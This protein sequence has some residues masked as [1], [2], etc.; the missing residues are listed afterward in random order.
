MMEEP[1]GSGRGRSSMIFVLGTAAFIVAAGLVAAGAYSYSQITPA[2]TSQT[3][4][5]GLAAKERQTSTLTI[6][7]SSGM[8]NEALPLALKVTAP[9][10]GSAVYLKGVPR[11]ALLTTGT[12]VAVGEWRVA[13]KDLSLVALIP[14]RDYTGSMDLTAGDHVVSSGNMHLTWTPPA[15]KPIDVAK[16][17]IDSAKPPPDVVKPPVDIAKAP[18]PDAPRAATVAPAETVRKMPPAELAAL[19]KRGEDLASTG[20]LPAA[21]LLLQRAAETHDPRAAFALAATYDPVVVKRLA[22]N[23]SSYDIAL[24]RTW[25]EKARD[26]G[27]EEAPRKLEALASGQR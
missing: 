4:K 22:P 15:P 10:P 8:M 24:A 12:L 13:I 2:I 20:D 6:D 3:A 17:S 14:P 27:S 11:D 19:I 1:I 21:R 16:S 18:A 26:W 23:S 5:A 7:H 25:Y 9:T